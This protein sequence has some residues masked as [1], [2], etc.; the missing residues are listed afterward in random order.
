M[1]VEITGES[2]LAVRAFETGVEGDGLGTVD[3]LS[4]SKKDRTARALK[5]GGICWVASVVSI[6]IPLLHF[7]LVP[8][9]FLAGPIVFA[10]ILSRERVIKGGRAKCPR[11]AAEFK[12]ERSVFKFPMLDRCTGCGKELKIDLVSTEKNS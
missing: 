1:S 6:I 8:G 5:F 12:I 7:V 10:T 3:V 9:F 4:W 11:C 2:Q